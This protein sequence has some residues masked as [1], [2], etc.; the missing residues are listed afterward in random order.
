MRNEMTER[1]KLE[2]KS[3]TEMNVFKDGMVK[4]TARLERVE[5][6]Y[7]R[8]VEDNGRLRDLKIKI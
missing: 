2:I 4:V 5:N 8:V 1:I 3:E 6:D 7:E